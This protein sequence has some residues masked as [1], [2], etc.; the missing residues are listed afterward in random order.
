MG[1]DSFSEGTLA[2]VVGFAL[3]DTAAASSI[4]LGADKDSY[5]FRDKESK[6][7]HEIY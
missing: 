6:N 4:A 7:T 3:F 2:I 1:K 5:I